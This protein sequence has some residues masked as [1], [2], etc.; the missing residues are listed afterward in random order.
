MSK[1]G[2]RTHAVLGEDKR[3]EWSAAAL[4]VACSLGAIPWPV[5]IPP[6]SYESVLTGFKT[7]TTLALPR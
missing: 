2:S 1:R 6:N 3:G 5:M 7:C 4:C